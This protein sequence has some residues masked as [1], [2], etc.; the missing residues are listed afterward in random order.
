MKKRP[1][2]F[3]DQRKTDFD[4]DYEEF[5]KEI[6]DVHVGFVIQIRIQFTD[7]SSGKQKY[8]SLSYHQRNYANFKVC[9]LKLKN[10]SNVSPL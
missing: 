9:I 2:N 6:H 5:C 10:Y 4:Q 3:L 7:K 1:Y 8:L